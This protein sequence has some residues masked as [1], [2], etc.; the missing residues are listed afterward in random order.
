[1]LYL[2]R[3]FTVWPVALYKY[4]PVLCVNGLGLTWSEV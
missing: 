3:C 1:M 4:L 2:E